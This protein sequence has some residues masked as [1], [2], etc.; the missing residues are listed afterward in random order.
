MRTLATLLQINRNQALEQNLVQYVGHSR[1][2]D[3]SITVTINA[4]VSH[5]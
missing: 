4:G 2:L 3:N 5:F 1:C